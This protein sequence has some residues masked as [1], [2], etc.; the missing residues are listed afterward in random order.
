[1]SV[2]DEDRLRV[3]SCDRVDERVSPPDT[4][5]DGDSEAVRDTLGDD[6]PDGVDVTERVDPWLVVAELEGVKL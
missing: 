5:C 4:V 6:E 2:G 3:A 1:M